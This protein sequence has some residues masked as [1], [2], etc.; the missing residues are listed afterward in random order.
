MR[1]VTKIKTKLLTVCL[2]TLFI[3]LI[4]DSISSVPLPIYGKI[5][6]VNGEPVDQAFIN[7]SS[8]YGFRT[9]LSG[10][11][12]YWQIDVGDPL[13]WPIETEITITVSKRI[14]NITWN[15]SEESKITSGSL[16]IETIVIYLKGM[17]ESESGK[18]EFKLPVAQIINKGFFEY[19]VGSTVFFD[20]VDS[21]DPD[22]MITGYR[23][24]FNGDGL[25]DT[26]WNENGVQT[27]V[28][29]SVGIYTTILEVRDDSNHTDTIEAVVDISSDPEI[30]EIIGPEMALTSKMNVFIYQMQTEKIISNVTWMI[31]DEIV[32]Y[33]SILYNLFSSTGYHFIK[34]YVQDDADNTYQ[35]AH[36][37][38]ITLDTD[39]DFISDDIETMIGTPI[40]IKNNATTLII[41][42]T[43][44]LIID[45]NQDEAYDLFFNTTAMNFSTIRKKDDTYLIDDDLDKTYDYLYSDNGLESYDGADEKKRGNET[46][47]FTFSWILCGILLVLFFLVFRKKQ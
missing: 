8:S 39:K 5:E 35:D 11:D 38:L 3:F 21:Y 7:I 19:T 16:N 46:P 10:S 47:G 18:N 36:Q 17:N 4:S 43:S 20:G 9:T 24:D 40:L 22:G 41:Q 28:F 15:A 13:N 37:I 26:D 32:S 29:T 1:P 30:I 34:V 42:G 14:G 12:G 44:H 6:D 25:Y 31:G 23:W 33:E 27:H 2:V 45:T